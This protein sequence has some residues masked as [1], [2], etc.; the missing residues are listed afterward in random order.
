LPTV[1]ANQ[2]LPV[3]RPIRF[4]IVSGWLYSALAIAAWGCDHTSRVPVGE[5]S[6]TTTNVST[7]TISA[8]EPEVVTN[9]S[10]DVTLSVSLPKQ[11]VG[12]NETVSV[13]V[14]TKIAPSF[15]LY[16]ELSSPGPFTPFSIEASTAD[17]ALV[18]GPV[19]IP[20]ATA[21]ADGKPVHRDLLVSRVPLRIPELRAAKFGITI[22]VQFQACNDLVC[23]PAEKCVIELPI[24]VSQSTSL[25]K[26]DPP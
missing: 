17:G 14:E 1:N 3:S 12:A 13:L 6:R 9:A 25:P 21:T 22:V 26:G 20:E 24:E 19:L 23:L 8:A 15:H 7:W 5:D 10:G 18:I 16:D 11:F 2:S 4:S